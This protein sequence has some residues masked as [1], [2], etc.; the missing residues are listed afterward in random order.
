MLLMIHIKSKFG[1][2]GD[3]NVYGISQKR[4]P[5]VIKKYKQIK[6]AAIMIF[7]FLKARTKLQ[8]MFAKCELT[9]QKIKCT[10]HKMVRTVIAS[11]SI[12]SASYFFCFYC[13]LLM[14]QQLPYKHFY[15]IVLLQND[16]DILKSSI[17]RLSYSLI[18]LQKI[19]LYNIDLS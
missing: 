7:N 16:N 2:S 1:L 3:Q 18:I 4:I 13:T 14:H 6:N 19:F 10:I 5:H 15:M 9:V 12:V 8:A 17:P 11:E